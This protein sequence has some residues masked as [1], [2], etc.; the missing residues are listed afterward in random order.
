MKQ[1]ADSCQAN[2]LALRKYYDFE[3]T[4]LENYLR[5]EAETVN[6]SDIEVR[7]DA[8][9]AL[10]MNFENTQI[11]LEMLNYEEFNGDLRATFE[12]R[13]LVNKAAF[14]RLQ[15]KLLECQMTLDKPW[16]V[17]TGQ[18]P[19]RTDLTSIDGHRANIKLSVV[20]SNE[21]SSDHHSSTENRYD[22]E[23]VSLESH[24]LWNS[25]GE[26]TSTQ[27]YKLA[28]YVP[29]KIMLSP[30]IKAMTPSSS[31]N[32]SISSR[33]RSGYREILAELETLGSKVGSR[34]VNPL[35]SQ[36]EIKSVDDEKL[37]EWCQS[38]GSNG[39]NWK[40]HCSTQVRAKCQDKLSRCSNTENQFSKFP[41]Q[42]ENTR[43]NKSIQ[44]VLS[45]N[46]ESGLSLNCER[47]DPGG[48]LLQSA[49]W[50]QGQTVKTFENQLDTGFVV[51]PTANQV[52]VELM[53]N[54]SLRQVS[55]HGRFCR[56]MQVA[57]WLDDFI[58]VKVTVNSPV[59]HAPCPVNFP[60]KS[61][62]LNY[63]LSADVDLGE[64][65][66]F[67][68]QS[69]INRSECE[70]RI[71]NTV[72][73]EEAILVEVKWCDTSH[74]YV[75]TYSFWA[76][77]QIML[78]PSRSCHQTLSEQHFSNNHVGRVE[79]TKLW[80]SE[81]YRKSR[82]VV[83]TSCEGSRAETPI[84]NRDYRDSLWRRSAVMCVSMDSA[85]S[86]IV[87]WVQLL[88]KHSLDIDL[89]LTSVNLGCGSFYAMPLVG[90]MSY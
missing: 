15:H 50:I 35:S 33:I 37:C 49:S 24:N 61:N 39:R 28:N 18:I 47:P 76:T 41:A 64:S 45:G 30:V 62:S 19:A 89:Y 54:H 43:Q 8:I 52:H 82:H 11:E 27:V 3:M 73:Q 85:T 79:R 10:K 59:V 29:P 88:L 74:S 80:S 46:M 67:N 48:K 53:L 81:S 31:E 83:V 38:I 4:Q 36:L 87:W 16:V 78:T 65:R 40:V 86:L 72:S 20:H 51:G 25:C 90:F 7:L 32:S 2:L 56:L 57:C 21:W 70:S 17:T 55:L 13:F 1:L 71:V 5:E 77:R 58:C 63:A 9:D 69:K 60:C 14:L 75:P 66:W 42:F 84:Y 34:P 12:N 22:D 23:D 26:N 44:L 6:L 68:L